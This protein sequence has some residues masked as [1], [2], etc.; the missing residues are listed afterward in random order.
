MDHGD[1]QSD[2]EA[3][4]TLYSQK[5]KNISYLVEISHFGYE[6]QLFSAREELE[7]VVVLNCLIV[8]NVFGTKGKYGVMNEVT[9]CQGRMAH[10]AVG[11]IK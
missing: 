11:D 4:V 7:W 9:G 6:L 1:P 2:Y 3:K 10:R 8:W 5:Q